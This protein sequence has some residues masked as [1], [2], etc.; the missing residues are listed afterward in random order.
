MQGTRPNN[1]GGRGNQVKRDSKKNTGRTGRLDRAAAGAVR[2]KASRPGKQVRAQ[3]TQY[4]AGIDKIFLILV[5]IMVCV[6]TAMIFSASYVNALSRFGDSYHFVRRQLMMA[7]VGIVAMIIATYLASHRFIRKIAVPFFAVVLFLNY[8]TPFFGRTISGGSR[9][10]VLG[11][12]Q[13]QPSELLKLAVVFLFAWYIENRDERM[14][15]FKW[16]IAVPCA[17][18][19]SIA[20]AMYLQRHF[21]G[22]VIMTLICLI[23]IFI[24]EAPWQWLG[25]FAAVGFAG[26]AAMIMF[27][28]YASRRVT[29]WLDPWSDPSGAGFQIIQSLYAIASGGL[30]GVGL[31]QSRQKYLYLPEP[32]NDFIFAIIS[33]ELGF[34]G[35]LVI[36]GLFVVLIF[37]GINIAF[38]APDKF[39]AFVVIG[40]IIK[41]A[42]QFI[43]NLAVVTNTIPNTGIPLPFFSYGGTALVVLLVEMGIILCISRYSYNE[44]A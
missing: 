3:V 15:Q 41:V 16:G 44:K 40:I 29:Y 8:I 34:I 5:I 7:A 36:I 20:A 12:L 32:Q 23:I 10:I 33:E 27:T 17:I 14:R 18:I 25:G 19:L 11:G 31:G 38:H 37:R 22:L 2:A 42:I 35:A 4:K 13:F 28:D 9:W 6:G 39:S 26:V 24:G 1:R 43:L 30:T 21:S